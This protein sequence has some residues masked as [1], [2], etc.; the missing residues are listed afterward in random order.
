MSDISISAYLHFK[1]AERATTKIY[2]LILHILHTSI[3]SKFE[4]DLQHFG[5]LLVIVQCI[6]IFRIHSFAKYFA[7][8]I[9]FFANM[10]SLEK[11]SGLGFA[12]LPPNAT[13]KYLDRKIGFNGNREQAIEFLYDYK[14][15]IISFFTF[16]W[17]IW[18]VDWSTFFRHAQTS[19]WVRICFTT[20]TLIHDALQKCLAF[21]KYVFQG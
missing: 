16:V 12:R 7:F 5:R 9:I 20:T 3:T 21:R 14:H 13:H 19:Y 10:K 17:I 1:W 15:Y 18:L 4:H 11:W 2:F 6:R 8:K